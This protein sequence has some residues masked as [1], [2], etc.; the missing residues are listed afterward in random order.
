MNSLLIPMA[1]MVFYIG[2]V[3]IYAF[4]VRKRAVTNKEVSFKYFRTYDGSEK[5]PEYLVRLGRHYDNLMQAP[6]FFLMT[7]TICLIIGLNSLFVVLLAWLYV[8]SRMAHTW[9]HLGSNHILK[10]AGFFAFGW[11]LI[12]SLWILI[13][14]HHFN[15]PFGRI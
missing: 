11:V 13:I 15:N 8:L 12:W 1:V 3:G 7:S 9:I 2:G 14:V 4:F 5:P 6:M 10:R